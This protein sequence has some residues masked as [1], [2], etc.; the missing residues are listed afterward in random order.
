MQ[1]P[2]NYRTRWTFY[3]LIPQVFSGGFKK[4]KMSR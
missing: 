4:K 3:W 2:D 1:V